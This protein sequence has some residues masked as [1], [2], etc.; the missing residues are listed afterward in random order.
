MFCG[1]G[2]IDDSSP[3]NGDDDSVQR[4]PNKEKTKKKY[5]ISNV[6]HQNKN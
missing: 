1:F 6:T 5:D 2:E 3:K 4:K